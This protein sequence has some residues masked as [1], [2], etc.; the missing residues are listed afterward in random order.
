MTKKSNKGKW[1]KIERNRENQPKIQE[2]YKKIIT[3]KI[4]KI[5]L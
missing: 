5:R 4:A 2:N 1:R 3:K